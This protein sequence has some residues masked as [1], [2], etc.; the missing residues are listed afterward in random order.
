MSQ[1]GH[2]I[3]D[4]A[5]S[6]FRSPTGQYASSIT[7]VSWNGE[8]LVDEVEVLDEELAELEEVD[9]LDVEVIEEVEEL[10]ELVDV[11]EREVT[12]VVVVEEEEVVVEDG[13]D[14]LLAR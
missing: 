1:F 3:S 7:R 13:P 14:G 9:V 8:V 10:E 11:V 12:V 4:T 6:W 5:V 2:G